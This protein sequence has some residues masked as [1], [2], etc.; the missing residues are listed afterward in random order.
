MEW[1]KV[2]S[3]YS[4]PESNTSQIRTDDDYTI[5]S[6]VFEK[7]IL[8][9]ITYLVKTLNPY[10]SK[11]TMSFIE[12]FGKILNHVDRKSQKFQVIKQ[13]ISFRIF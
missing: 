4:I 2:I 11:Q 3:E 5:L 1:Y 7:I 10:S 6:K 13:S 9:R 8:P 12:I